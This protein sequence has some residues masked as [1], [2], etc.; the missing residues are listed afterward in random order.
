MDRFD[1]IVDEAIQKLD[2]L[3][4]DL[5]ALCDAAKGRVQQ[6]YRMDIEALAARHKMAATN[7]VA[8]ASYNAASI[9]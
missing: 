5:E 9:V 8:T 4:A 6:R 3:K 2:A 7:T 1:T